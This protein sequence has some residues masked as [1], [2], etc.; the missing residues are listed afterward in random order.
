M[1]TGSLLKSAPKKREPI[2]KAMMETLMKP[3]KMR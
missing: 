3:V 2:G 1:V